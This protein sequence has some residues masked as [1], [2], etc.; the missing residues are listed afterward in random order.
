MNYELRSLSDLK[1]YK[2]SSGIFVKEQ[3]AAVDYICPGNII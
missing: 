3:A 1:T 2:V